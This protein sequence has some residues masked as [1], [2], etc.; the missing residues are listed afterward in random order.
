[1]QRSPF[2]LMF[3]LAQL[4]FDSNVV[5]G[6][7]LGRLAAGDQTAL[8]EA[9]LMISEKMNAAS[10]LAIENAFA[11]AS[12]KSLHSVASNSINH[13]GKAVRANRKRLSRKTR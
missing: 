4:A 6:L 13:Y 1:M 11:L 7:R 3:D 12:G 9:Q 5:I 8:I 10:T 2:S